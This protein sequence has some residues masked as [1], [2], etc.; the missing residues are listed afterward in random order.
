[1]STGNFPES[2]SQRILAGII[3]VGRLGGEPRSAP[4]RRSCRQRYR[5]SRSWPLVRFGSDRIG[6]VRFGSVRLQMLLPFPRVR[7]C[8]HGPMD[9]AGV[10][11]NEPL[12]IIISIIIMNIIIIIIIIIIIVDI[13]IISYYRNKAFA[14]RGGSRARAERSGLASLRRQRLGAR[15]A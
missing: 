5:T 15:C 6:S 1:M 14:G 13:M 4:P 3:L 11:R 7:V 8:G 12:F 9:A 2:L 10:K